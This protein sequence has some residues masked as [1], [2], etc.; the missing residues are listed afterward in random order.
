MS[1]SRTDPIATDV[2]VGVLREEAARGAPV[3]F[4][5]HQLE[6]VEQRM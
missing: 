5:S 6:L 3:L 1:R 2:M 4:S